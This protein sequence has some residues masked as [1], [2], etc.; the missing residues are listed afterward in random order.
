MT[1]FV[2]KFSQF[3]AALEVT[4]LVIGL[5]VLFE[6]SR[7]LAR[8]ILFN[9]IYAVAMTALAVVVQPIADAETAFLSSHLGMAP[10]RLPDA[11]VGLFGSALVLMLTSDLIFYWVHRAQHRYT[12]LWAMHSFLHSD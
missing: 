10:V 9:S 11:G 2:D 4:L 1:M 6:S 5:A 8:T 12:V 3:V 7:R